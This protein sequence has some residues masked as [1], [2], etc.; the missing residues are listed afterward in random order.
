MFL[1][2]A[3]WSVCVVQSQ[4]VSSLLQSTQN[5]QDMVQGRAVMD[6]VVPRVASVAAE[7]QVLMDKDSLLVASN[8]ADESGPETQL[9]ISLLEDS[10]NSS[11]E[12][13][14]TKRRPQFDVS[15][16]LDYAKVNGVTFSESA[17]NVCRTLPP[18]CGGRFRS[19]DPADVC[20]NTVTAQVFGRN[21][22]VTFFTS[23]HCAQLGHYGATDTREVG[24]CNT[25]ARSS[26][27]FSNVQN[28]RSTYTSYRVERCPAPTAQPPTP[29]PRSW[30][31]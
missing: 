1:T 3:A 24:T 23:P 16:H 4:E 29:P 30:G 6:D 13:S 11:K 27:P 28:D 7:G 9:E 15:H 5:V 12:S 22:K 10:T 19:R 20:R 31:A 2:I 18:S 14:A 8:A 17:F 21:L 25:H 26:A